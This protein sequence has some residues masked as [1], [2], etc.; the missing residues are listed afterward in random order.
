ML[1]NWAPSGSFGGWLGVIQRF[2]GTASVVRLGGHSNAVVLGGGS[3]NVRVGR[4]HGGGVI[5]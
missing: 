4:S 2:T 5:L 3:V 1:A